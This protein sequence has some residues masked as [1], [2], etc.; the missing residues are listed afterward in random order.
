[1]VSYRI[2]FLEK[3][4]IEQHNHHGENDC[5]N[6]VFIHIF[7]S[8]NGVESAGVERVALAKPPERKPAAGKRSFFTQGF[9]R[10]NRAARGKATTGPQKRRAAS[11]IKTNREDQKMFHAQAPAFLNRLIRSS[12]ATEKGGFFCVWRTFTKQIVSGRSCA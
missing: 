4:G 9:F 1:L 8:L 3:H 5:F 11:A 12:S 7:S 2:K 6:G 10:I